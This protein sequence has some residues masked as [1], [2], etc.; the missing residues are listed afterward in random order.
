MLHETNS[1]EAGKLANDSGNCLDARGSS[2]VSIMIHDGCVSHTEDPYVSI[3]MQRQFS[4]VLSL[5]FL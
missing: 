5:L 2:T 4:G 1:F 3:K